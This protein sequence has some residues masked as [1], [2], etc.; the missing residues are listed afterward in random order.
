METYMGFKKNLDVIIQEKLQEFI[1]RGEWTPGQ[2]INIDE[3][4]QF[5]NVSRTPVVQALKHMAALGMVTTSSAGHYFVLA[6]TQKQ[7]KDLL[8]MRLLLEKQAIL[9]IERNKKDIDLHSL[10]VIAEKCILYN[11]TNDVVLTRKMD[12]LFHKML[13]EQADNHCMNELY[14]RVQSQFMVANYLLTSHTVAQQIVASDDHVKIIQ[15]LE[16][17]M[18]NS[19]IKEIEEHIEGALEKIIVKMGR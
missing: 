6:F 2:A 11:N 13:V 18:Y 12:L 17:K 4:V 1:L 10:K 16:K 19:A 8:E 3:L 9:D 15:A 7:V 14:K 5:F